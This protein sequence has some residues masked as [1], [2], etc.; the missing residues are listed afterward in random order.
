MKNTVRSWMSPEFLNRTNRTFINQYY[1]LTIGI[2][3]FTNQI[4]FF[5]VTLQ[6]RIGDISE[7]MYEM[8]LQA[9]GENAREFA[10]IFILPARWHW[11]VYK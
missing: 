2:F 4:L 3:P 7:K 9:E 10:L 6:V 11:L 8:H 5:G 1:A